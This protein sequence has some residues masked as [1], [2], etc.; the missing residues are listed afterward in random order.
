MRSSRALFWWL[1][2]VAGLLSSLPA[3]AAVEV[4]WEGT[5]PSLPDVVQFVDSARTVLTGVIGEQENL[6]RGMAN[7]NVYASQAASL[8]GYQGYSLGAVMVGF[9]LGAELP[10]LSLSGLYDLQHKIEQ[11]MDVYAGVGVGLAVNIGVNAGFFG[12]KPLGR[13]FYFNVKLLKAGLP[14]FLE[15]MSGVEADFMTFGVGANYQLV[16]GLGLL[17]GLASWRGVSVGSGLLVNQNT[18]T[19]ILDQGFAEARAQIDTVNLSL[20]PGVTLG[21]D[22]TVYTVPFE[23][24]TSVQLFYVLNLS[25]G[26]GLDFHFGQS[27]VWVAAPVSVRVQGAEGTP[28]RLRVTAETK[29]VAPSAAS[30]HFNLGLGFNLGPVKIDVPLTWYVARGL[31]TGLS[32]G[33]VW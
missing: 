28:A 19:M 24:T 9:L 12:L 26:T 25:L 20:D 30:F 6:A 1:P 16:P 8:Q 3:R 2:A 15:K 29:N 18:S 4:A 21:F 10:S 31:S 11:Q 22:T 13:D 17:G 33:V 14:S 32:L 27:D 23:V 7:G 5:P